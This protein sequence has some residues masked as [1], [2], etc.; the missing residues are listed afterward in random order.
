VQFRGALADQVGKHFSLL[1]PRQVWARR[2]GS[3][4]ELRSIAGVLR[5][6]W[7]PMRGIPFT[8]G[9]LAQVFPSNCLPNHGFQARGRRAPARCPLLITTVPTS[10][11]WRSRRRSLKNAI[12]RINGV[13]NDTVTQ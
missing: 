6:T 8:L 5:Q 11:S 4:I 13:R 2:R 3:E 9:L 1:L 10:M 12:R 7:L